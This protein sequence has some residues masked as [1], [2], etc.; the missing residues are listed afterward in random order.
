MRKNIF[1]FSTVLL[2]IC[3]VFA[4]AADP[5]TL[6]AYT[7]SSDTLSPT[8]TSVTITIGFS[9][10]VKVSLKITDGSG[11]VVRSLY[12][13]SKVTNPTPKVWDGTN[14]ARAQVADGAYTILISATSV[15]TGLSMTDSSK[16]ITV[17]ESGTPDTSSDSDSSA[18][19]STTDTATTTITDTTDSSSSGGPAEYLPIPALRIVVEGDR[20]ISSD[21]DT[22][23]TAVVYDGNGNKRDDAIISWSFGD[24]DQKTGSSVLHSYYD[25]GEYIA[26]VHATTLDGGDARNEI[27]MTVKDASLKIASVSARGITLANNDTRTLD[28]SLWRLS[29]GGQEFKI[30]ADTEILAGQTILFPAQVTELPIMSSASLLYPSGEVA[31]AYP[32]SSPMQLSTPSV[33][34]NT[35]QAVESPVV[36]EVEPIIST[37]SNI[38]S[39]DE[40]VGAPAAANT[41]AAAGAALSVA[42]S[43]SSTSQKTATSSINILRSPWTFGLLGTVVLAGGAFILL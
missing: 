33:S 5:P 36:S 14:D 20:T 15:A 22:A 32:K 31:D 34:N 27:V 8:A 39:H 9:E 1:I 30:P 3:P 16:T 21:A 13:S 42:S 11:S 12:S 19:T 23:F 40:A 35:I 4:Y 2:F 41:T 37:N 43:S 25:P 18:T 24:G 7:I 26:V 29:E 6:T 28:L 17:A 38:Q 10:P